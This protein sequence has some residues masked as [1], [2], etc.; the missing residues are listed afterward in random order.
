MHT[1]LQ[2]LAQESIANR[3]VDVLWV[4]LELYNAYAPLTCLFDITSVICRC[5]GINNPVGPGPW[6]VSL[7]CVSFSILTGFKSGFLPRTTE[8]LTWELH[9]GESS[10]SPMM[11]AAASGDNRASRRHPIASCGSMALD[12]LRNAK[13]TAA[14]K[15]GRGLLVCSTSNAD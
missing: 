7:S 14:A 10:W 2:V 9:T 15:I 13:R 6:S 5:I 11:K 4:S 12:E 8:G 1:V 3:W